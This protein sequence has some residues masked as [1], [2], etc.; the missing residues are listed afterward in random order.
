MLK[1]T[2]SN[3]KPYEFSG[4]QLEWIL[5]KCNGDKDLFLRVLYR[6]KDANNPF[7]FIVKGFVGGYILKSH[8]DEDYNKQKVKSFI[9]G[10]C[11]DHSKS[12][13]VFLVKNSK[14]DSISDIIKKEC[15]CYENI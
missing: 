7:R 11:G 2:L 1:I 13:G 12:A 5:K 10:V 8:I 15:L 9:D 3:G 6:S 14:M 4:E